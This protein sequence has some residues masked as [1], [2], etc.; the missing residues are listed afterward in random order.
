M[1]LGTFPRTALWH[2]LHL[3]ALP[4]MLLTPPASAISESP[5][6]GYFHTGWM[7]SDGAPSD[8]RG[9]V[10]D[11]DGWL[12]IGGSGGLYRFDGHT[13]ERMEAID[14]NK[15]H[16]TNI[17]SLAYLDGALWVGY[18]FGGIERFKNGV[19]TFFD[20]KTGLPE[21]SVHKIVQA[22]GGPVSVTT[23]G[24]LF[25]WNGTRWT[26]SW[27]APDQKP[28]GLLHEMVDTDGSLLIN[29]AGKIF[30]KKRRVRVSRHRQ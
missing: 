30:R 12:W 29:A 21:A 19:A 26:R 7:P 6:A 23:S 20:E 14:G 24:G 9:I 25:E 16:K 15:L 1:R 17:L 11:A 22:P 3:L 10:Q 27:P 4:L 8:I 28:A 2:S 13:F 5:F 18:G